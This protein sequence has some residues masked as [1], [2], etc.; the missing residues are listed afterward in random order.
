MDQA[1]KKLIVLAQRVEEILTAAG[2]VRYGKGLPVERVLTYSEICRKLGIDE[3]KWP[4]VKGEMLRQ[5]IPLGLKPWGGFFLG[6]QGD[7]ASVSAYLWKLGWAYLRSASETIENFESADVL[8][9]CLPVLRRMLQDMFD[10]LP[11]LAEAVH[12]PFRA[13]LETVLY[14]T[15]GSEERGE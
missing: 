12:S 1:E 2:A 11:V 3:K 5:G 6:V 7:Q 4:E 15:S 8:D 13:D 14:L 10:D 9:E